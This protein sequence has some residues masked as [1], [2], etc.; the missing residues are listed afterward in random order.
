MPTPRANETEQEFIA[1]CVIDPEAVADFP[2]TDQRLAFC[3]SQYERREQKKITLKQFDKDKYQ[4]AFENQLDIV[5]RRNI[6]KVKRYYR[7]N[8]NK[9]IE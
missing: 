5:E 1:R 6:A 4:R 2:D 9:G 8:Y 7:E 3:Y